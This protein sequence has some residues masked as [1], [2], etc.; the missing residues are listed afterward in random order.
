MKNKYKIIFV[1]YAKIQI[2]DN[3]EYRDNVT[4]NFLKAIDLKIRIQN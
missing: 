2:Y 3:T 1:L 4:F